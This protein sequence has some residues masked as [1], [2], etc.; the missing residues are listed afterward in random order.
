MDKNYHKL[1]K[2]IKSM[3]RKWRSASLNI[4]LIFKYSLFLVNYSSLFESIVKRIKYFH[5]SYLRYPHKGFKILPKWGVKVHLFRIRLSIDDWVLKTRSRA[6][7]KFSILGP[8]SRKV[9][10]IWNE[11]LGLILKDRPFWSFGKFNFRCCC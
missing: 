3:S 4:W 5:R 11:S 2:S 1:Y 10:H 8:S 7:Y 9:Y 6:S